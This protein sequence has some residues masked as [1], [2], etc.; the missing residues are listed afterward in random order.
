MFVLTNKPL[1]DPFHSLLITIYI[2]QG[3][4]KSFRQR[5]QLKAEKPQGSNDE[6]LEVITV[7]CSCLFTF[8]IHRQ[9]FHVIILVMLLTLFLCQ[10]S[11][12]PLIATE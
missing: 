2:C 10:I 6:D 11:E 12:Q 3:D 4:L 7:L 1:C 5:L 9:H 8:C